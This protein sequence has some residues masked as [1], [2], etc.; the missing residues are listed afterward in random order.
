MREAHAEIDNAA[1]PYEVVVEVD[2]DRP[3]DEGTRIHG[4]CSKDEADAF[5][6]GTE[7][8]NDS[9]LVVKARTFVYQRPIDQDDE[10]GA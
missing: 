1:K 10:G 2:H 9:A 6:N 3:E 7:Y 5:V 4:P 8:A